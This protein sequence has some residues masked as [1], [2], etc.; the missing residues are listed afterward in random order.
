MK[1]AE[2]LVA[3]LIRR[4]E[5]VATAES[6]TGGLVA[7]ALT[8]VPGVSE[9][10][11][12]GIVSYANE[13]KHRELGVPEE[14][15][16]TKGA[17]S[18]ECAEAMALGVRARFGTDWSVVT[19]GIAGPGG[20]TPEKPVGLVFIGVAGPDGATVSRNLFPGDRAAVRAAT[21]RRAL[22]QLRERVCGRDPGGPGFVRAASPAP[23][24]R[25]EARPSQTPSP[26][27]GGPG[28]VRAASPTPCGRDEARP[29]QAPSPTSTPCGRDEARPSQAPSPTPG[30][31]GFV[32]AASPSPR[33]RDEARP[34]QERPVRH[35]PSLNSIH[36]GND[37]RATILFVS[38]NA[39]KRQRVFDNPAAVDCILSAWNDARDWLVGRYVIMP[40]HVHFCCAPGLWPTPDFHK[41]MKYWKSKVALSFPT[42]HA[43]PL[44]QRQCWDTQLR[45]GESF[46]EKCRYMVNNPVRKGLVSK[47]EDWPYQGVLNVF[48]WHEK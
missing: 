23:C 46:E 27:S 14:I 37:N 6:C 7:A 48:T 29:S 5:T 31:P 2:E 11:P 40:D 43:R 18:A 44:W 22:G 26:A 42:E 41:W 34:S 25:D 45:Q 38:V 15:L 30:G 1:E 39:N 36:V 33:G 17:V 13:V 28:F 32:R 24:G 21:V 4:G 10:Y 3:E 16:A 19:T 9:C 35:R 8:D 47:A 12:G 20:G